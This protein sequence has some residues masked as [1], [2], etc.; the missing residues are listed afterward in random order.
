[1]HPAGGGGSG[2]AFYR[3][4]LRH[5]VWQE[6][7]LASHRAEGEVITLRPTGGEAPGSRPARGCFGTATG[8]RRLQRHDRQAEKASAGGEALVPRPPTR[9]SCVA[10]DQTRV[11]GVQTSVRML[12]R[13]DRWEE[14]LRRPRRHDP[15]I[16]TRRRKRPQRHDRHK[17]APALRPAG[18]GES[19]ILPSWRSGPDIMTGGKGCSPLLE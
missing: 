8:R 7:A 1:M 6:K 13:H 3:R 14:R 9:R 17:E 15:D 19:S 18:G 2:I 4:R 12:Q 5:H 10:T 16:T 11:S